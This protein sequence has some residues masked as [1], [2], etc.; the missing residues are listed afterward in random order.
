MIE[1]DIDIEEKN[2]IFSKRTSNIDADK[3]NEK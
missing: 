3:N 2:E 1:N